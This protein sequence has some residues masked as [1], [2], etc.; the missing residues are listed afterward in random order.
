MK[1][2]HKSFQGYRLQIDN[3]LSQFEL[4]HNRVLKIYGGITKNELVER[5]KEHVRDNKPEG[6]NNTWDIYLN[7]Q[8][9]TIKVDTSKYTLEEYRELISL[10]EQYLINKLDELFG[11]KCVNDR[12]E[13]GTIAQRGGAG[14]HDLEDG[15]D[16]KLYIFYKYNK[17]VFV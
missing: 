2:I 9:I 1:S 12:N 4:E 3:H 13:D 7:K 8:L 11:I 10:I 14:L 5:Y 15:D 6:F 16:Y 17:L